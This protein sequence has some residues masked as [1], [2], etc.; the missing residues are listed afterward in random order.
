MRGLTSRGLRRRGRLLGAI[1]IALLVAAGCAPSPIRISDSEI[2]RLKAEEIRVVQYEPATIQV[3]TRGGDVARQFGLIGLAAGSASDGS[4]ATQLMKDYGLQDPAVAVR[5]QLVASLNG[6]FGLTN[7]RVVE[8]PAPADDAS[9]LRR[10]FGSGTVLDL[11]TIVWWV[12]YNANAWD[13]YRLLYVAR[14]RLVRL[15]GPT[16][17]WQA[18]CDRSVTEE[19]NSKLDDLM[20]NGARL[21]KERTTEK[22]DWC[23]RT[24]VE[25]L[26][27]R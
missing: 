22:V 15:D 8:E 5:D 19:P 21:L 3:T 10:R 13:A 26:R 12:N 23:A 7:V 27:A 9:E 18:I 6:E 1:G 20:A 4:K 24:L 14:A 11:K 25:Q 17:V 2:A 16:V